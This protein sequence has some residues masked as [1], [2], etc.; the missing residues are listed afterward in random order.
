M[1]KSNIRRNGKDYIK[2]AKEQLRNARILLDGEGFGGSI[3]RSY[4]AFLDAATACLI[5]KGL[6][7]RSHT[8]LIDLFSLHFIKIGKI[9]RKYIRWLKRIK[10][11]R[12]DADYTHEK[13]FTKEDAE[14]TLRETEEFVD[15]VEKIFPELLKEIVDE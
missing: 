13:V 5:T 15:L 10:K 2:A 6:Y 1:E 14:G 12:E 4:Y 3:S 8:G 11:D 7:P 9:D